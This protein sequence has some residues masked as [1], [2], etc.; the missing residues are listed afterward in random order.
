MP[1]PNSEPQ[2]FTEMV[3]VLLESRF[4]W[5][6]KLDEEVSGADTVQDLTDLHEEL[7]NKCGG[8]TSSV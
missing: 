5:L 2:T 4:P 1:I 8:K 3:L 7:V 6:G